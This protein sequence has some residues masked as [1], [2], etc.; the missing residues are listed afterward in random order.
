MAA[1]VPA[2][3]TVVALIA[4]FN[5]EDVIDQVVTDLIDQGIAV[6]LIDD[7]ST[8]RTVSA[9]MHHLGRGLLHVERREP[10]ATFDW[11]ALLTR[12][13]HLARE[14]SADWFL[15]QDADEFR[16]SPWTDLNLRDA[17]WLVQCHGYNAV[18]FEVLNF[19]P[20]TER[21]SGP[22]VRTSMRF[23][24]LADDWDAVQ[25]KAWQKQ[26]SVDL[27][28]VGGHEARFDGRRIFPIP[29]LSRHYPIRSQSHGTRKVFAERRP[30]FVS[31]ELQRG[32][33]VQYDAMTPGQNFVREVSDLLEFDPVRVR[34]DLAL[35]HRE[36]LNL[37][38]QLADARRQHTVYV[39]EIEELK[40]R[41]ED[42]DARSQICLSDL[43]VAREEIAAAHK[44][45][46]R[47]RDEA[48][49][50][51][52]AL[53]TS[54]DAR[55]ELER[56]LQGSKQEK[57]RLEEH[58]A[59]LQHRLH[60]YAAEADR[61]R[62]EVQELRASRSWR[63]T[64]PLRA[65]YQLGLRTEPG[66]GHAQSARLQPVSTVWG[67]DRGIPIDRH[68]I[69]HFLRAHRQDVHGRVLE[70]KDSGYA[71]MLDEGQVLQL[72]VLDVDGTNPNATLIAD[73]ARADH[74]EDAQF[75]CFILTQTL[76]IIYDI[77]SALRHGI[78]LLKPGGVLLCTIPA[79]SRVNYENGG[80]TSGDYWRLT[81][82][83]V[84]RLFDEFLPSTSTEIATYG[85]VA[86]CSAFLYGLATTE[87][88]PEDLEFNDPWFPL[89]HCIRAVKG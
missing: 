45:L 48:T 34:L 53:A 73:L 51:Q 43:A 77:H 63:I 84:R 40:R 27:T 20:T 4:A 76:H 21:P 30:R 12:K 62:N 25:V 38:S 81:Q 5:E 80:V 82:A 19:R 17:L 79:I 85:N 18:D 66:A 88:P 29:F 71:R 56:T 37:S 69:E 7:G 8:D 75:D 58:N 55:V 47:E 67:L 1:A 3:F 44:L 13:E 72:D 23:Y 35:G 28:S 68:Y 64:A 11:S 26:P 65:V 16:E 42:A 50:L 9:V 86:V 41:T 14:L 52:G 83:A 39:A 22:D 87:I 74:L 78:R 36:V 32:W 54:A 57:K 6:Y 70:V 61:S 24:E 33:H 10:T 31:G 49:K 46:D 60:E 59:F 15:H 89:I 2:G